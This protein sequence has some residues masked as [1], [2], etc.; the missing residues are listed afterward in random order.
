VYSRA[1]RAGA[2]WYICL[3]PRRASSDS[4]EFRRSDKKRVAARF[5]IYEAILMVPATDLNF[6]ADASMQRS[7]AT[8]AVLFA[9]V[10]GSTRLY[11]TLGDSVAKRMVDDCIAL[12]R[13]VVAQYGGR[14]IKTIGDEVMCVLP[15]ADSACLAAMDMQLKTA[16]L[17]PVSEV[18][19]A[20]RIG[21][22]VGVVIEDNNDVFGDTVNLAARMVALAKGMQII[23]TQATVQSL[24]RLLQ[25]STRKI[26]ALAIK[27]KGDDVEVCEILWQAGEE[28]TMA[29]PSIIMVPK[30]SKLRLRWG[31]TELVMEMAKAGILIG[32]DAS[33]Q[34]VVSD[35]MASR[36]H[37]RI[38]RLQNKFFLVDESTNGTYVAI[39]GEPEI[40]LRHEGLMLRGHGRIAFGRSVSE[41]NEE[42]VEFAMQD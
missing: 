15:D 13:G 16:A 24:S 21:F 30:R 7:V 19:R 40:T 23:T 38:E 31:S 26:A 18:K 12:M 14:V 20:I 25:S 37:A 27:G 41:S 2:G 1:C 9:D 4:L 11:D 32:R 6:Q 10:A 36:Q 42:T 3:Y 29:T 22:H 17:P 34:I 35:R 39:V 28:L 33:C 5:G 8:M